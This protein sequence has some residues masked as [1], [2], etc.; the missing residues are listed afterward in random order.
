MSNP[1]G[2]EQN[3]DYSTDATDGSPQGFVQ[4][5]KYPHYLPNV[6]AAIA[7]SVGV[8]VGSFGPG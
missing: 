6:V 2:H 1:K 8:V 3:P 5:A 4:H 7:A